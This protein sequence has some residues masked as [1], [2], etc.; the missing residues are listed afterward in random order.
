[1]RPLG[2]LAG[3]RAGIDAADARLVDLLARRTRLA[4]R[5]LR[6]KGRGRE[7]DEARER[8]VLRRARA[9]AR[10][11]GLEPALVERVYKALLAATV[12]LQKESGR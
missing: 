5:T 3:L 11:R 4:L 10:A 2:G 1:M 7:R 9:R 8:A 6:F 12:K